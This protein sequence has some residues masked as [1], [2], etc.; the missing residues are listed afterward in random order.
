MGEA[1]RATARELARKHLAA[2][3]TLGWFEAL[4]ARAN[5]DAS[6][7][8]WADLTPNPNL[9][10][11]LDAGYVGGLG[12]NALKIG[13]G[14]G[15]DA[16]ELALR[17]FDTTAFDISRT[18]ISWCRRRHPHSPVTYVAAD[19]LDTPPEWKGAFYLNMEIASSVFV[20]MV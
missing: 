14:L 6:I 11:W 10:D 12:R 15:D 4:Y 18:A 1:K 17:G 2:G 5:G 3:D 13:C 19:L 8:P 7:I 9:V 20:P 16:E